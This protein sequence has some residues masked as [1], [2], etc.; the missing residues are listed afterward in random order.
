MVIV[1]YVLS[2]WLLYF[3]WDEKLVSCQGFVIVQTHKP[4]TISAHHVYHIYTTKPQHLLTT[5]Y[6]FSG[7][8]FSLVVSHGPCSSFGYVAQTKQQ[9]GAYAALHLFPPL[10]TQHG[11]K[12]LIYLGA[13]IGTIPQVTQTNDS[14]E[15]TNQ[16]N[17]TKPGSTT[18]VFTPS[19]TLLVQASEDGFRRFYQNDPDLKS[20]VTVVKVQGGN[21]AG[22]AHY[23]P[24]TFPVHDGKR[25]ISLETQQ[26]LT[27]A[28]IA[29]FLQLA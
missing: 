27:A 14:T 24:Q 28:A 9:Q 25:D 4:R 17:T 11:W 15:E 22:V 2:I 13:G 16:S 20:V 10:Q 12:K 21:H 26:D 1:W 5:T 3:L 8:V 29:K 7:L 6:W 19:N 18:V 23:G